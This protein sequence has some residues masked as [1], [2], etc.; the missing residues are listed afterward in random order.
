[1]YYVHTWISILTKYDLIKQIVSILHRNITVSSIYSYC[2]IKKELKKNL[3]KLN[4]VGNF[5]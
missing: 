2:I 1:M 5:R 3:I 4:Y